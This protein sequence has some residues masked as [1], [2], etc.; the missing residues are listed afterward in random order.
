MGRDLLPPLA[1]ADSA[2]CS[3]RAA[4]QTMLEMVLEAFPVECRYLLVLVNVAPVCSTGQVVHA[5]IC[6]CPLRK[7]ERERKRK[8]ERAAPLGV[9]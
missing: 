3:L 9:S 8:K 2:T 1:F 5:S 6:C 4:S 7:K